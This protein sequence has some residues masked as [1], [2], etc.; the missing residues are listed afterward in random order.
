VQ[1]W[2]G[3]V[4]AAR[5]LQALLNAGVTHVLNCAAQQCPAFYPQVSGR[6]FRSSHP[7]LGCGARGS[8]LFPLPSMPVREEG[9]VS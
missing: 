8:A 2:L 7:L 6:A 5:D 1:I 4:N 9:N 3:N